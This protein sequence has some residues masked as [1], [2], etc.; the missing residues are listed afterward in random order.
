M[1][2]AGP[3]AARPPA[4]E[5]RAL[6]GLRIVAAVWVVIFHFHF[7][8]LPGV[9]EVTSALGPLVT[10]GSLGVDLFFVLSGFVI[11]HN[12]LD[13]LGPALQLGAAARFLWARACRL[14]PAY[15]VVLHLFGLW[16]LARL[17]LDHDGV[18]AY[19]AAQ[20][21]VDGGEWLRQLVMVQ[22]W[23]DAFF[24]GASWVG[25]TWSISAEWLAYVVFP[26]LAVGF[27]RMRNLPGWLLTLGAVALMCPIGWAYLS[28]GHPYQP[29]SWL[30][31]IGCGFTA[32]VL[33]QLVVR[34]LR[35][36]ERVRRRAS[37]LAA[38]VPALAVGGLLAGELAG[39]GR[40]GAV[41]V[42]F[43][44]LIGAL[45][46]ADRGPALMLAR[47][48][49]V[50][51]GR[52]S[53]SLYLVHIPIFE[54][55]WLALAY[56]PELRAASWFSHLVAAGVVLVTLPVAA[57]LYRGVE[58]PGRR[59]MRRLADTAQAGTSEGRHRAGARHRLPVPDPR[60]SLVASPAPARVLVSSI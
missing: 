2:T 32:G 60:P 11:A 49:A 17:L 23:D 28:D 5:L 27:F 58:E 8:A 12:Y 35:P 18:I 47:P 15:V 10:S 26:V 37:V 9:A 24:D 54:V 53:Y 7:T 40:G 42:L 19:Q 46:V 52:A 38:V 50:A 6:T 25:P 43:P 51:G 39:P 45:A 57:L 31:R 20:P 48:W 13:R 36:T 56:F 21:V 44:L 41:I 29:W 34:R 22:V 16:L 14:W 30:I 59:R 33:T 55:Y 4:G 1:T 3:D